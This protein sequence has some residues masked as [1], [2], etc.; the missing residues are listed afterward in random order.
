MVE[1]EALLFDY[2][3]RDFERCSEEDLNIFVFVGWQWLVRVDVDSDSSSTYDRNI[4]AVKMIQTALE[5][6]SVRNICIRPHQFVSYGELIQF[7]QTMAHTQPGTSWFSPSYISVFAE[8]LHVIEI[9]YRRRGG[10]I[11]IDQ[12][13]F[14]AMLIEAH[15]NDHCKERACP[16][17]SH[18]CNYAL[19]CPLLE[20]DRIQCQ[21]WFPTPAARRQEE[22]QEALGSLLSSHN[23]HQPLNKSPLQT[24][25]LQLTDL[26][27]TKAN[28]YCVEAYD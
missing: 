5:V 21:R 28:H 8:F 12:D 2:L 7:A 17:T 19:H 3:D 27:L 14:H 16:W 1:Y 25:V 10:L 23:I 24:Q 13:I 22:R 4:N 15:P 18:S 9:Y 20:L 26:S 11:Q 6:A